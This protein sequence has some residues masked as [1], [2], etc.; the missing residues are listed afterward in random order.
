M[1]VILQCATAGSLGRGLER[2][3]CSKKITDESFWAE[4]L[5]LVRAGIGRCKNK[6]FK[7]RKLSLKPGFGGSNS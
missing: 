7:K 6:A 2:D 5:S 4:T 1:P 3:L